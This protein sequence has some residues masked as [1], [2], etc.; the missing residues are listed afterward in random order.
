MNNLLNLERCDRIKKYILL[1]IIVIFIIGIYVS[2]YILRTK[3]TTSVITNVETSQ[4]E[5]IDSMLNSIANAKLDDNCK[6]HSEPQKAF[7]NYC[8]NA[9]LR[10]CSKY[11]KTLRLL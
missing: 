11:M 6:Y 5:N 3:D 1:S 4:F 8:M 2:V 10:D 9:V 7:C